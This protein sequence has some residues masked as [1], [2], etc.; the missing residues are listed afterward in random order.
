MATVQFTC[1][2]CFKVFTGAPVEDVRKLVCP[3][4]GKVGGCDRE[5]R[6]APCGCAL[7]GKYYYCNNCGGEAYMCDEVYLD[8]KW[9]E[10]E[11]NRCAC[12]GKYVAERPNPLPEVMKRCTRCLAVANAQE[13]SPNHFCS[14]CLTTSEEKETA[15]GIIHVKPEFKHVRVAER[16]GVY[17]CE[18]TGHIFIDICDEFGRAK[19]I[20]VGEP[21][22]MPHEKKAYS[23]LEVWPLTHARCTCGAELCVRCFRSTTTCPECHNP[24]SL[25]TMRQLIDRTSSCIPSLRIFDPRS[26]A[27]RSVRCWENTGKGAYQQYDFFS[28]AFHNF[29][30]EEV[31]R[32]KEHSTAA[33]NLDLLRLFIKAMM[34]ILDEEDMED[35]NAALADAIDTLKE[36]MDNRGTVYHSAHGYKI[37]QLRQ[38][39]EID[40][41]CQT[42]MDIMTA[43][44]DNERGSILARNVVEKVLC[45]CAK[46]DGSGSKVVL[47]RDGSGDG[48]CVTCG[49]LH[50]TKCRDAKEPGHVCKE[51]TLAMVNETLR[52]LNAGEGRKFQYCPGCGKLCERI[53][54]CNDMWC[55]HCHTF[56]KMDTGR[57]IHEAVHNADFDAYLRKMGSSAEQVIM[58]RFRREAGAVERNPIE[59]LCQVNVNETLLPNL[60]RDMLGIRRDLD[61]MIMGH[62]EVARF[63]HNVIR[64][65]DYVS[66]IE[67]GVRA[68]VIRRKIR[69]ALSGEILDVCYTVVDIVVPF[70]ERGV[71]KEDVTFEELFSCVELL[72]PSL[73]ALRLKMI[74]MMAIFGRDIVYELFTG[75]IEAVKTFYRTLV[76]L[77]Q[78]Q[79]TRNMDS[80]KKL[81]P[82]IDDKD[83]RFSSHVIG[84]G[85]VSLLFLQDEERLFASFLPFKGIQ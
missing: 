6:R 30:N 50:C 2:Y 13:H 36:I 24:Y 56:F 26:P 61:R 17:R 3:I 83:I 62:D 66:E 22:H 9:T 79:K 63:T 77:F 4:C 67:R 58:D 76:E 84:A 44:D 45:R 12:G 37:R 38:I 69:E 5:P 42:F 65:H 46:C 34:V 53:Q 33:L 75:H 43:E 31:D 73:A 20:T 49:L 64:S 28:S 21:F 10:E 14:A 74:N 7:E 19:N 59:M 18:E 54:G 71:P 72:E 35:G 41:I 8:D 51:E 27:M 40:T 82:W 25:E 80:L 78:R 29:I 32:L 15:N 55:T 39:E 60:L 68:Y 16:F 70:A 85:S 52:P 48:E 23:L 1:N 81:F 57:I 11:E 47:K